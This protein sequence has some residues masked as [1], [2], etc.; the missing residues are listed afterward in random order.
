MA[1][2]FL[3][4][5]LVEDSDLDALLIQRHLQKAGLDFEVH[6][7]VSV[8]EALSTLASVQIDLI[9]TDYR[10]PGGDGLA[11]SRAVQAMDPDL[12]CILVSGQIG[13]DIA[14]EALHAGAR[15]FILKGHLARLVPAIQREQAETVLRR[16]RHSLE[17][18]EIGQAKFLQTLLDTLPNPVFFKDREGRYQGCNRAFECAFGVS[19]ADLCGK[20]VFELLPKTMAEHLH[21]QDQAL[22][23]HSGIQFY[24]SQVQFADGTLHEVVISKATYMDGTTQGVVGT[25]MD[26]T[27]RKKA[28]DERQQM[29][30]QLRQAQKLEAIGQLAAGIAHE[31]NTPTQYIGDNAIFLRDAFQNVLGFLAE[32]QQESTADTLPD[33]GTLK[34]RIEALDLDYLREEIP[35]AIQQSLEGVDR[36]SRIVSAMKD[37]SHPGGAAQEQ[38]DLNRA[39]EST[40]TVSHN[41]WHYVA[42]LETDFD[43]ELPLVPCFASE[44]NQV[45]L[46]LLVNAAHAI[47]EANASKGP[48][49]MGLIRVSTRRVGDMAEI[50]I[51]DTGTGIPEQIQSRIFEPFFTTKP[52]GKGT[53]QGLSIAHGVI[54]EKHH[55]RID[56]QSTQGKGTTFILQLPLHPSNTG[57]TS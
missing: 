13:E 52:V 55:G 18:A 25:L 50:R 38:V 40:L 17:A 57:R 45:V 35:R 29:E 53:G 28:E 42:T 14:V 47:E 16:Q 2:P 23:A 10:L 49:A 51:S 26:I 3:R 31:I 56:F 19:K 33:P 27:A 5:L 54:V 11:L 6:R 36:V 21:A 24:Q 44:F 8:A 32:L 12:P 48:G 39:I 4:I 37:F 41:A 34:D 22:L 15:D 9:L 1:P 43:P 46:N 30:A 7:A 20:T